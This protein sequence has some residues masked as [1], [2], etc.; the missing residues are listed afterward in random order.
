MAAAAILNILPVSIMTCFDHMTSFKYW[1]QP[2]VELLR[3]VEKFNMA[4]AAIQ[5]LS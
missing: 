3:F 1:L 2:A 4:D 5:V